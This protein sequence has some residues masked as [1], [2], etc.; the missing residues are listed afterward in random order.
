MLVPVLLLVG[1]AQAWSKRNAE[2]P[3]RVRGRARERAV[4]AVDWVQ[5][6]HVGLCDV[7]RERRCAR[8]MRRG[9]GLVSQVPK[10][11]DDGALSRDV[12]INLP[13]NLG[14]HSGFESDWMRLESSRVMS[15]S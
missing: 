2:L 1:G 10:V 6:L 8:V 9:R 5:L 12:S 14:I 3:A 13:D 11:D 4:T 7:R 15:L